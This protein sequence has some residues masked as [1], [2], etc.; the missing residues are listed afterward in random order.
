MSAAAVNNPPVA[1]DDVYTTGVNTTLKVYSANGVLNGDTD[2]DGDALR[3]TRS[4]LRRT[5]RSLS[6]GTGRSPTPR[7][8][9]TAAPT[10]LEQRDGFHLGQPR[11]RYL[12]RRSVWRPFQ[13]NSAA[14]GCS[15]RPTGNRS[16]L[17]TPYRMATV[18]TLK[19][20][21]TGSGPLRS[22]EPGTR[23]LASTDTGSLHQHGQ[24]Q[25]DHLCH[26]RF[27]GRRAAERRRQPRSRGHYLLRH[28][29]PIHQDGGAGLQHRDWRQYPCGTRNR[30]RQSR[31]CTRRNA[32]C[33]CSDDI[34]NTHLYAQ[35]LEP[36]ETACRGRASWECAE[37]IPADVT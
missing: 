28:S 4:R 35:R 19:W 34:W 2:V 15:T 20:D 23:R 17:R 16:V 26:H 12:H 13:R 27:D 6:A 14:S 3:V 22:R 37:S 25:D 8:P 18:R 11:D 36:C 32:T 9:I 5:G 29:P 24:W 10:A 21:A 31:L 30:L 1:D 33:E 7:R